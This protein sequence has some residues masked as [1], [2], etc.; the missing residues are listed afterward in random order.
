MQE[1]VAVPQVLRN[2]S[3]ECVLREIEVCELGEPREV[4]EYL[5]GDVAVRE[6]YPNHPLCCVAATP[7]SLPFTRIGTGGVP[8]YVLSLVC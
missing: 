5:P 8:G 6:A 4:F 2:P 7:D 1:F 3:K